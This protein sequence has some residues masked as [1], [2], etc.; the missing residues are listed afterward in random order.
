MSRNPSQPSRAADPSYRVCIVCTGNICRSPMAAVVL[1][2]LLEDAG[3]ADRV[4]VDSAGTGGWH[5]G[6]GA[7]R[8]ALTALRGAGYDGSSHRAAQFEAA[9]LASRDLVLV[10]D[11]GHLRELRSMGRA[12]FDMSH[13]R[14]LREFDPDAV[15]AGTL[16]VDDPYYGD[17]AGFE[18][19][20]GEIVAACAGVVE[21]LEGE[22]AE[23]D[24]AAR[25]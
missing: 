23:R 18:R 11:R 17:A 4:Q 20:L 9:W 3:L 12:G 13:V 6:D 7:D 2:R 25:R 8:R 14:L 21:H 16:D 19:C 22:L 5:I 24:P 15:A 10:A 1:R